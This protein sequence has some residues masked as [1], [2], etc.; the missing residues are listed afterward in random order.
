MTTVVANLTCKTIANMVRKDIQAI[1]I[2][3]MAVEV[4]PIGLGIIQMS[5][6]TSGTFTEEQKKSIRTFIQSEIKKKIEHIVAHALYWTS[7]RIRT[8][9]RHRDQSRYTW[10]IEER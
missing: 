2:K 5:F 4:S 7:V 10:F 1:N 9:P 6:F 3:G 8:C